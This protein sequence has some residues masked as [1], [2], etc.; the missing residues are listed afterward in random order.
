MTRIHSLTRVDTLDRATLLD[1]D[2]KIVM[3][4]MMFLHEGS[5]ALA[6][7]IVFSNSL[8]IRVVVVVAVVVVV[9]SDLLN[10]SDLTTAM[11]LGAEA[12][13]EL[14]EDT[15]AKRSWRAKPMVACHIST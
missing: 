2:S 9:T 14:P 10:T 5:R 3:N 13:A 11:D 7:I 1:M 12:R 6:D 15:N 8:A 4:M